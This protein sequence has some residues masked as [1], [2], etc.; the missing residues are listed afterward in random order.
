MSWRKG[1]SSLCVFPARRQSE[2]V[3]V[4]QP[5]SSALGA[6]SSQRQVPARPAEMY[7]HA[8]AARST[9]TSGTFVHGMVAP[10]FFFTWMRRI[11]QRRSGSF[12][13]DHARWRDLGTEISQ[14]AWHRQAPRAAL[15]AVRE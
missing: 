10:A 2:A 3:N 15:Y 6:S 9:T 8:F 14:T 11:S 4:H 13:I 5:N 7:N 12:T 1:A